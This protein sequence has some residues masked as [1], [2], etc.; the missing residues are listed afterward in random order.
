MCI[1]D[2]SLGDWFVNENKIRGGLKK[3]VDEINGMG[4]KFGLWFEPEMVCPVSYTH[5]DVYKRQIFNKCI[6]IL[7]DSAVAAALAPAE[8]P[9]EGRETPTPG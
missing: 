7:K 1:R 9:M 2:S 5:L 8:A 3:L 4:M 6:E